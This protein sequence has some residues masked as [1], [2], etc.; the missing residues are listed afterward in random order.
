MPTTNTD[1]ADASLISAASRLAA[2]HAGVI[3]LEKIR[4]DH[5]ETELGEALERRWKAASDVADA[6]VA[7]TIDGA[8]ARARS[9]L[10]ACEAH[11]ACRWEGSPVET[12]IRHL[13]ADIEN[14]RTTAA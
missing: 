9:I 5:S 11:T 12:L 14:L 2:A 1:H 13:A 6:P 8:A 7:S 4:V 10:V 3:M